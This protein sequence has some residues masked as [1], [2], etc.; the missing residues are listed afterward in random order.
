MLC[1][2]SG[3][4]SSRNAHTAVLCSE[5][6]FADFANIWNAR[7]ICW[8]KAVVAVCLDLTL[9]LELPSDCLLRRVGDFMLIQHS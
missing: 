7:M 2:L 1:K 5:M 3:N 9:H 6:L 8:K 4:F